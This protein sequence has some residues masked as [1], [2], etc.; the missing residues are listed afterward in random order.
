MSL[1]IVWGEGKRSRWTGIHAVEP[2]PEKGCPGSTDAP[3]QGRMVTS[4]SPVHPG[5]GSPP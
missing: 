2:P 1:L 3:R 4:S 5:V